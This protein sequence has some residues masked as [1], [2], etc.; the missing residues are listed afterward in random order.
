[1]SLRGFSSFEAKFRA[2][3]A[4]AAPKDVLVAKQVKDGLTKEEVEEYM[5]TFKKFDTYHGGT[6]DTDELGK[7][8]SILG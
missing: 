8:V 4:K 3:L 5:E 1:M 6:I 2:K 7:L